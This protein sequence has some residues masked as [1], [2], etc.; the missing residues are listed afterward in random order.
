MSANAD[1]RYGEDPLPQTVS[2]AAAMRRLTDLLLV[3][4]APHP[5]VDEMLARF[6]EWEKQ[7]S[8]AAPPDS[9]PRLGDGGEDRRVYLQHA[10]DVGTY[11]PCFPQYRFDHL[12]DETASGSVTFAL[13]FEG[14]PGLVHGGFLGVFFDCVT[15]HQSCAAGVAGKTRSLTVRYRRPTPVLTELAFD[16]ARVETERGLTSTARLSLDGEVLCTGEV[17]TVAS[18]P[19]RLAGSRYGRRRV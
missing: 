18:P 5:A 4:E 11:N 13:A 12:G 3:Q 1:R 19:D 17:D 2:A 8:A 6:P 10:F 16:V 7:L 14:P 9:A 15:Q